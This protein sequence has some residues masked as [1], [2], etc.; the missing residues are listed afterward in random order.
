MIS[1]NTLREARDKTGLSQVKVA[2]AVG[3][4][5]NAYRLWELGGMKPS[6]ANEAKLREVLGIEEGENINGASHTGR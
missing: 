1:P 3:V 6:P 5:I 2:V 4:S